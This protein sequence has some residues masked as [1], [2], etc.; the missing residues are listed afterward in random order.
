MSKVMAWIGRQEIVQEQLDAQR[1]LQLA[2]TLSCP[3]DCQDGADLPTL[4]HWIVTVAAIPMDKVG[5]D[6][7]PQKGLFLPPIE[8]PRRMW[9]GGRFEFGQAIKLG[10]TVTRTSTIEDIKYK[11]GRTGELAFV[12]VSHA[13]TGDQGGSIYEEHDIVYREDPKV[14]AKNTSA[15][16]QPAIVVD[17]ELS[18]WQQ[19]IQADPV[20]LFRYSALTFN[21]HRIHYDRE[22]AAFEGYA[23]L[24]VHG[25]LI[26]TYM[27]ELIR[28]HLPEARI[29][30]FSFRALQPIIDIHPFTVHARQEGDGVQVW[31]TD[32]LGQRAMQGEADIEN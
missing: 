24:V 17:Q 3:M 13:I 16:T 32:H 25:P 21:G 2:N 30:K 5:R 22:Y 28:E 29:T 9:A 6:G 7:H 15:V 10:E 4:W 23:G 8:L 18:D 26:A 1:V 14:D 31:A 19:T 11:Q 20:M 27:L 12:T